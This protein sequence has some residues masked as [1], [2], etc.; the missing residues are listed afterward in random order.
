MANKQ[1]MG[2]VKIGAKKKVNHK[3]TVAQESEFEVRYRESLE[4]CSTFLEQDNLQEDVFDVIQS[5]IEEE[6]PDYDV[7]KLFVEPSSDAE[8]YDFIG[9]IVELMA[10]YNETKDIDEAIETFVSSYISHYRH[11]SR[12]NPL[13]EK[14]FE[15]VDATRNLEEVTEGLEGIG[16]CLLC[17]GQKIQVRV[18]G[19]RAA[20]EALTVV[21][22]CSNCKAGGRNLRLFK[23]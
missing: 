13:M 23:S 7:P 21:Y 20:D 1:D 10:F 18:K 8:S 2:K 17:R 12:A 6:M 3:T 11:I 15:A 4:E 22:R 14:N 5:Q 19:T 9:Q 16:E